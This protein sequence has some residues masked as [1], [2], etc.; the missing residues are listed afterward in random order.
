MAAELASGLALILWGLSLAMPGGT[1]DA[2]PEYYEQMAAIAPELVW[3]AVLTVLGMGQSWVATIPNRRCPVVRQTLAFVSFCIWVF[4]SATVAM[5]WPPSSGSMPHLV[6]A[7]G[8]FWAY[9]RAGERPRG[10]A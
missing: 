7:M 9:A 10:A 8:A 5:R 1:F 6:L 3:A 4:I 2:R